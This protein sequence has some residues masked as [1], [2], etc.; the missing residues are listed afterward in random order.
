[1][2]NEA[3]VYC[4]QKPQGCR[5]V[6]QFGDLSVHLSLGQQNGQCHHVM[7]NCPN[8]DCDVMLSCIQM[9]DHVNK[10]KYCPFT[11]LHCGHKGTRAQTNILLF[12]YSFQRKYVTSVCKYLE[13]LILHKHIYDIS[14]QIMLILNCIKE[15]SCTTGLLISCPFTNAEKEYS[16]IR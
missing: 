10:C 7:L 3:R 4:S 13:F 12:E 8:K 5:W 15:T 14:D 11:C 9:K 2:S 6:G 16:N 1:M